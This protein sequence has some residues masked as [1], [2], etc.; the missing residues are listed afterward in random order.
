MTTTFIPYGAP[1]SS[2]CIYYQ[3]LNLGTELLGRARPYFNGDPCFDANSVLRPGVCNTTDRRANL[4][5]VDFNSYYSI[6]IT[7]R[8]H[9]LARHE[10][11]HI[12]GMNGAFNCVDVT[13][14]NETG[15]GYQYTRLQA[16]DIGHLNAWY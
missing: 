14:M 13:V 7:S 12:F 2:A 1:C 15:C 9:F 8:A 10:A 16:H 3:S 5:Y 4:G 6:E 11:G